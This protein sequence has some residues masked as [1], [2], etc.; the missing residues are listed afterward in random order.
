M[1]PFTSDQASEYISLS[2]EVFAPIYPPLAYGIMRRTKFETRHPI[3]AD[4]GGGAGLLLSEFVSL[5]ASCGILIDQN[6]NMAFFAKKKWEK[7]IP[8]ASLYA[9]LGNSEALPLANESV[10]LVVSRNSMHLWAN[11]QM[12]WKNVWRILKPA[13]AAFIGRGYGPDLDEKTRSEVKKRRKIW[14]TNRCEE[15]EVEQPSP[16]P[17]TIAQ[18]VE[19]IGFQTVE[20]VPDAKAYWIMAI[21]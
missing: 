15:K 8:G 11:I 14:N 5:G 19:E 3:V 16:A 9:L 4:L 2:Q 1:E 10:D 12:A 13:G 20:I 18:M 7:E 6:I 17:E 21:K